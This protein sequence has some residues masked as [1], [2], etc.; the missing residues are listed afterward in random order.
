MSDDMSMGQETRMQNHGILESVREQET[1]SNHGH[2]RDE[3]L[4]T[5]QV[6]E[7]TNLDD[8]GKRK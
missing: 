3:L 2:R 6:K 4:A 7:S 5:N 8:E 1:N